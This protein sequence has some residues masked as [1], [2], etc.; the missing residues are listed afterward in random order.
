MSWRVIEKE[1]V[2]ILRGEGLE[3]DINDAAD[4]VVKDDDGFDY[5]NVTYLAKELMRRGVGQ[6]TPR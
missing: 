2:D 3:L 1:L 5:L 6:G 4:K